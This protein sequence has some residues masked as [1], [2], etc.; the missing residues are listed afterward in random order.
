MANQAYYEWCAW[1]PEGECLYVG[2]DLEWT[3]SLTDQLDVHEGS[4]EAMVNELL[5]GAIPA[6]VHVTQVQF[7]GADQGGGLFTGGRTPIGFPRGVVLSTGK[8]NDLGAR[9]PDGVSWWPSTWFDPSKD[10]PPGNPWSCGCLHNCPRPLP[11]PDDTR[12]RA[13]LGFTIEVDPGYDYLLGCKYNFGSEEYRRFVG[14]KWNDLAAFCEAGAQCKKLLGAV[15]LDPGVTP[16]SSNNG[17]DSGQLSL[18]GLLW[19]WDGTGIPPPV[20]TVG[21]VLAGDTT[22]ALRFVVADNSD[23]IYDSAL[24]VKCTLFAGACCRHSPPH[25]WWSCRDG[26]FQED[27]A[28]PGMT[29][30]EGELCKDIPCG[31]TAMGACCLPEEGM[32]TLAHEAS[33]VGSA[34]IFAGEGTLCGEPDA[35]C[36]N[37]GT[38][39][40][41][42]E[43]CCLA[44]GGTYQGQGTLCDPTGACY[45]SNPLSCVETI[46]D[47]CTG[48]YEGDGTS[49]EAIG[50][51]CLCDGSCMV[52]T[53]S[54]CEASGGT[55]QG[56]GT[57]C[58]GDNNGNGINDTCEGRGAE[59]IPT[60][61][62]WGLVLMTLLLL[63]GAK[64]CLARWHKAVS[65]HGE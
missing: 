35:C 28:G 56:D 32:C 20:P 15:T 53:Q 48:T 30:H 65:L 13:C 17:L 21:M 24:F 37:D 36:L 7:N 44:A 19:T 26:V 6:G 62:A 57:W 40:K 47:C 10:I 50:A 2:G 55:L 43:G 22:R 41:V 23:G 25:V 60:V 18:E 14:T 46:A 5:C 9:G 31:D 45:T 63:V 38:C 42:S 3:C 51:C 4:A 52:T 33:C 34:G 58:I 64:I 39:I 16:L 11:D 27:C 49:C 29:W 8:V 54:S 1:D 61:S 12:D 59:P